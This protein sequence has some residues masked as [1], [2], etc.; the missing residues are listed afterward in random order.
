[1]TVG[2]DIADDL[3]AL[4]TEVDSLRADYARLTS[5]ARIAGRR[6]YSLAKDEVETAIEA[7]KDRI[8]K[9]AGDAGEAISDDIEE[10]RALMETYAG[11]TQ[12]AIAAHPLT[13][14][15]G[16]AAVAFLLGRVTR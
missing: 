1:M 7:I 9:K 10:L 6:H 5:A 15:A 11:Q 8:S 16:A 3:K 2:H 12:K 4:K 14:I 13:I